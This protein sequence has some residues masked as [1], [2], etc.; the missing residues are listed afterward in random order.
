MLCPC[1]AFGPID[2]EEMVRIGVN[3]F[4]TARWS[5][6]VPHRVWPS[7]AFALYLHL[8]LTA[9]PVLPCL[10]LVFSKKKKVAFANE[11]KAACIC[12]NEDAMAA[13]E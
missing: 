11:L 1:F 8:Y 2:E 13:V 6:V 7:F 10:L 12:H 4:F 5:V 3:G 9:R